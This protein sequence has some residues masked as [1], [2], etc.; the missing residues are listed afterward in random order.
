[1]MLDAVPAL[2]NV[3]GPTLDKLLQKAD[4][5]ESL[6]IYAVSYCSQ[7]YSTGNSAPRQCFFKEASGFDIATGVRIYFA[8]SYELG[9]TSSVLGVAFWWHW[10]RYGSSNSRSRTRICLKIACITMSVASVTATVLA[11]AAYMIL[12]KNVPQ[13]VLSM[14]FGGKFFALTWSACICVTL[15]MAVMRS[16]V[17]ASVQ[18]LR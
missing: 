10:M 1:M 12:A 9:I 14:E 6:S 5:P 4:V 3:L 11:C 18:K 2:A 8:L 17:N 7:K 16:Q 13:A 15:A